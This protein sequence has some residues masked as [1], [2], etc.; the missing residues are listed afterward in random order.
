MTIKRILLSVLVALC[1]AGAH[2][3]ED[4]PAFEIRGYVVEGNTLLP[5][6]QVEA[7]LLAYTGPE[8]S[9]STIQEAITALEAFYAKSGYGAVK[10]F[11]P[12]QDVDQGL[13]RLQVVEAKIGSIIISGNTYF[14]DENIRRSVPGLREGETPNM[15]RIDDQLRLANENGGKNTGLVFRRNQNE[16]EVDAMLN[17]ADDSPLRLS[18]SMDNTGIA[19]SDG[20]YA[21]GRFRTGVVLQHSNLFDRDHALSLQYL[22]SPDHFDKVTILG[23]G[24]RI[25]LYAYGDDVTFAYAYSNVNSGKLATAAGTFGISGSGQLFM[26][27]YNQSLPKW[28]G[29]SQKL[30]YGI[31]YKAYSSRI[32]AEGSSDSLVPDAT[33]HP[34]SLTYFGSGTLAGRDVDLSVSAVQNIPGGA[35]GTTADFNKTGARQ[36]ATAGY[37]LWRYTANGIQPLPGDWRLRGAL[38]GQMTDKALISGEQFGAGGMDSVRGF[39]ERSVVNDYGQRV[40]VELQTPD[41]GA[42]LASAAKMRLLAFYDTAWLRRRQALASEV[43]AL[44]I[45]SHGV[46]VRAVYAK[47]LSLRLDFAVVDK[48]RDAREEG[49][50]MIHA[51][52]TAYF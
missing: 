1:C 45:A 49:S 2:A 44:Q 12:E 34:V 43:S 4:E 35:D 26:A 7:V 10:A 14:S 17:V 38:Q 19:S 25:P 30:S 32:M 28:G 52:I 37:H 41:L 31:D 47:N 29:W 13:I 40:T 11:L 18:V 22:T 24:Y 39:N 50:K 46:G 36:G 15:L 51:S 20:K 48:G 9:F 33:V 5:R 16:G 8:A 6:D 23:L 27:R 21:T 42:S 3:E